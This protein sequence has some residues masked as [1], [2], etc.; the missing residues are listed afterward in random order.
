VFHL[1]SLVLPQHNESQIESLIESNILFGTQLAEAMNANGIRKLINTGTSWQHYQGKTYS[2]VCLY[3]AT[4]QAYETILTYYTEVHG[5]QVASLKL[6]D[7]YGPGD[8]R[9]KVIPLL[10]ESMNTGS[11]L[12][13]SP[14]DQLMDLVYI[15]DI[16]SAYLHAARLV[17]NEDNPGDVKEYAISSGN[18]ISLKRLVDEICDI[19]GRTINV[20]W[21]G[22]PYRPREVMIPW[23]TG[24]QLPGWQPAVSLR[25]GLAKVIKAL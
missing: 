6:F 16:V 12:M 24:N 5:L 4:K 9:K 20:K 19:S 7:T 15:D 8:K 1:A 11:E 21:G 22:R 17:L 3:A 10:I 2:P 18:P 14:G 25:E 13:M 23:R